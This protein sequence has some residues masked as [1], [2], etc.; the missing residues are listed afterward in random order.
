MPA[1]LD[2][3]P[4]ATFTHDLPVTSPLFA[5]PPV[6]ADEL[7]QGEQLA[8]YTFGD[9]ASGLRSPRHM[10][11][12]AWRD[13]DPNGYL[14][15]RDAEPPSSLLLMVACGVAPYES[16][17]SLVEMATAYNTVDR[18]RLRMDLERDCDG[19]RPTY[20]EVEVSG[21]ALKSM[22]RSVWKGD[23]IASLDLEF[24]LTPP[25]TRRDP[26]SFAFRATMPRKYNAADPVTAPTA[27]IQVYG[28]VEPLP[29]WVNY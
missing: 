19:F 3:D 1:I 2:L 6:A 4:I 7:A 29:K 9:L 21:L 26:L 16:S 13:P 8:I 22:F 27:R 24:G 20:I 15:G 28:T 18:A 25:A 5:Y 17:T 14:P 10:Y 23:D 11:M 12:G